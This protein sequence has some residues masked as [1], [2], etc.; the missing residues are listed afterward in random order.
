MFD[1]MY[2]SDDGSDARADAPVGALPHDCPG[3][4]GGSLMMTTAA[5][6]VQIAEGGYG[7]VCFHVDA[8]QA[9]VASTEESGMVAPPPTCSRDTWTQLSGGPG[10]MRFSTTISSKG[11]IAPPWAP[12]E[13]Q[14]DNALSLSGDDEV[15]E[16]S[17]MCQSHDVVA[18]AARE[19][20]IETATVEAGA[21]PVA[22]EAPPRWPP[23]LATRAQTALSTAPTAVGNSSAKATS[24]ATSMDCHALPGIPSAATRFYDT[25]PDSLTIADGSLPQHASAV[26]SAES[27]AFSSAHTN[28]AQPDS[29]RVD[30][31][32][33]TSR[34]AVSTGVSSLSR[35][36]R[37]RS[38]F[39]GPLG[40]GP[41]RTSSIG[42]AAVR[43]SS[44][45]ALPW[46]PA[47]SHGSASSSRSTSDVRTAARLTQPERRPAVPQRE[48]SRGPR[49]HVDSSRRSTAASTSAVMHVAQLSSEVPASPTHS[50]EQ[51]LRQR[52]ASATSNRS[53]RPSQSGQMMNAS[54]L[55]EVGVASGS[56]GSIVASG[57]SRAKARPASATVPRA[58]RGIASCVTGVAPPPALPARAPARGGL[59]KP[60]SRW[61]MGLVADWTQLLEMALLQTITLLGPSELCA[62][63]TVCSTWAEMVMASETWLWSVVSSVGGK[64]PTGVF[65]L[66]ERWADA[67]QVALR[68]AMQLWACRAHLWGGSNFPRA[69][70]VRG[71]ASIFEETRE[72]D[73]PVMRL[74]CGPLPCV[75]AWTCCG[76]W[77]GASAA[78][79][80]PGFAVAAAD[81]R[82]AF[83]RLVERSSPTSGLHG[84]AYVGTELTA[85]VPTAHGR[86]QLVTAV[87]PLGPA[88]QRA[89]SSGMDGLLRV[90]DTTTG[91]E[92]DQI[93]TDHSQAINTVVVSPASNGVDGGN[94]LH[95]EVCCC[96]DDGV[97]LIYDVGMAGQ[98]ASVQVPSGEPAR[99][100]LRRFEGHT[101]SAYCATWTSADAIATGGFDRRVL[102]WDRRAPGPPRA[103]LSTRHH[104]Y[105]VAP[106]VGAGTG[107]SFSSGCLH[108]AAEALAVATSD[109][110][111][112][113][114]D[115]RKTSKGPLREMRGHA[116]PVESLAV[117]PGDVL[118]S[119]STDGCLRL[120]N[121]GGTGDPTWLWSSHNAHGHGALT[122]VAAVSEDS[123]LV[124]G[125]KLE[126]TV[127]ALNYGAA[128]KHL[129]QV[130][131]RFR[132][133][134]LQS[135]NRRP[136]PAGIS[137]RNPP[138]GYGRHS[139][140]LRRRRLQRGS[141]RPSED[142]YDMPAPKPDRGV[143]DRSSKVRPAALGST[144]SAHRA[145]LC[146]VRR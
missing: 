9:E 143:F 14:Q 53:P 21:A 83:C 103:V 115:L 123:L 13:L 134:G 112:A 74:E 131:G 71:G 8:T 16:P 48:R 90:W 108:H 39:R 129:P 75:G 54:R 65:P 35:A 25:W 119:V 44:T 5:A 137:S 1:S 104:V 106:L 29:L 113:H 47:G 130:L 11:S 61:T 67:A 132:L 4:N 91:E 111:I 34:F 57:I 68:S 88:G 125:V 37:V 10:V 121:A 56:S 142:D 80:G 122:S 38:S 62:V 118:A 7:Q 126:P 24:V 40:I 105:A 144:G 139:E 78:G 55:S 101:A 77:P 110:S 82:L 31:T 73:S 124:V 81:G 89:V 72:N 100:P 86:D 135:W 49:G 51:S 128:V 114:W 133:P 52:G 97:A 60:P 76:A 66:L 95:C 41:N 146:E 45:T 33:S 102:V 2:D 69:A 28:P 19:A 92:L 84:R 20:P 36:P 64:L 117:L 63:V 138:E 6:T 32:D 58:T 17:R 96:G 93:F 3:G 22:Q 98:R 127:V 79:T 43:T 46:R 145:F 140:L 70:T 18:V 26:T 30:G 94:T 120:W 85:C 141:A 109:G 99:K 12:E 59:Q 27:V 15:A 23:A 116:S 87:Q 50:T 136:D 107:A 42:V